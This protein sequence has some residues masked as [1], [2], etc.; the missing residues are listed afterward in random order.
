MGIFKAKKC[1][2]CGQP[3]PCWCPQLNGNCP[4][5]GKPYPCLDH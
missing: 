2:A 1:P 3:K 5:C 4:I